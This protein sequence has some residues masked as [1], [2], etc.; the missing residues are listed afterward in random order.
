MEPS[1]TQ[2]VGRMN[3]VRQTMNDRDAA[4]SQAAALETHDD[5]VKDR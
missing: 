4:A 2:F 3:D 5:T 1:V